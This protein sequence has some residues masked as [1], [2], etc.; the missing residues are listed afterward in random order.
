MRISFLPALCSMILA[1]SLTGVS[2]VA[3]QESTT[4]QDVI[5]QSKLDQTEQRYV[6]LL[7][8]QFQTDV[9]HDLIISLHGHGSDR[10]QFVNDERGECKGSRDAATE[11]NAIFVSPDYRAKTSWMGSAATADMRQI[12][13]DL[14]GQYRIRNVIISGGSMGATSAMT[15]AALHPECI[16]G[17]V[18]LNG[19]ANLGATVSPASITTPADTVRIRRCRRS[20]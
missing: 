4:P 9:P 6:V 15:F 19:T 10:W 13:D 17:V 2:H 7:P 16:D 1:I 3:A 5:F 8:A 12:L 18:S 14:H 11:H 20:L